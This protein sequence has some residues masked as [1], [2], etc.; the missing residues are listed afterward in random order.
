MYNLEN[1]VWTL[2]GPHYERVLN[3]IQIHL[4]NNLMDDL[5]SFGT[6]L[7]LIDSPYEHLNFIVKQ[8]YASTSKRLKTRA[9][10]TVNILD[11]NLKR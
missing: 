2:L 9:K 7:V 1:A 6:V 5:E 3:T 8:T 4:L 11:T 10:D